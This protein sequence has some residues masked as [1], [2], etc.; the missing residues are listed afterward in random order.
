MCLT[1]AITACQDELYISGGVDIEDYG[2]SYFIIDTDDMPLSRATYN[3]INNT[4]FDEGDIVGVFGLD[5]NDNICDGEE[6]IPYSVNVIAGTLNPDGTIAS[7]TKRTLK[8]ATDKEVK[9]NRVKYLFYYPY[10]EDMTFADIQNLK[11]T[12]PQTKGLRKKR[13]AKIRLM[14]NLICCGTLLSLSLVGNTAM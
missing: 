7:S 9:K 6:N 11:H 1:V 2:D 4:V 10:Q 13:P 8:P 14:K 12:S 3:D 5:E